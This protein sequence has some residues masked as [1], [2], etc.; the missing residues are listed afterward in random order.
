[1]SSSSSTTTTTDYVKPLT[2]A[3]TAFAL[4]KFVLMNP[5]M[6]S[7]AYFGA[8]VGAALFAVKMVEVNVPKFMPDIASIGASGQTLSNRVA[9]IA[10]GVGLSYAISEFVAKDTSSP[11]VIM[12]RMACVVAADLAGEYASD[13]ANSRPLSYFS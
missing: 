8:S 13:Y 4:D 5:N 1:M 7:S 6:M 3:A 12:K 10:G 11:Q 2:A 9:E